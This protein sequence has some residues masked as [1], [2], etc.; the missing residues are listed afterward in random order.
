MIEKYLKILG[1]QANASEDMIKK[2]YREK[3]KL[4]HPD[5]SKLENAHEKFVLLTEAYEFMMNR[6]RNPHHGQKTSQSKY[7][8]TENTRK[9]A[10]EDAHRAA[11]MRYQDF[12]NSPYYKSMTE[13]S[14]VGDYAIILLLYVFFISF[15]A[16]MYKNE[17]TAGIIVFSVFIFLNTIILIR[18]SKK[19]PKLDSKITQ[20]AVLS[21]VSSTAFIYIFTAFAALFLFLEFGLNTFIPNV[22]LFLFYLIA[23]IITVIFT[24]LPYPFMKKHR[25]YLILAF[26]PM[27]TGLFFGLNSFSKEKTIEEVHFFEF[28]VNAYYNNTLQI[29]DNG[30]FSLENK[31]YQNITGI[32]FFPNYEKA[33]K[34][35]GVKFFSRKGILGMRYL[36]DYEFV[37]LEDFQIYMKTYRKKEF[38]K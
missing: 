23:S 15:L 21:I 10:Q 29:P 20:K 32:R 28:Q 17:V 1:V 7:K 2:A 3:A 25:F 19:G 33:I 27:M 8:W 24:F 26:A 13:I 38:V 34:A 6:L 12:I 9:K 35:A 5:V 16:Y 22:S 18:T 36:V 37:S 4:Y 31:A 30:I 14:K 11:Q